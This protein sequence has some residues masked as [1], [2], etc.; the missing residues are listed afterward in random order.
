MHSSWSFSGDTQVF[1]GR[2]KLN[3]F[4]KWNNVLLPGAAASVFPS[5]HHHRI[6]RIS[7][8]ENPGKFG[9]II[10]SSRVWQWWAQEKG[11]S[12]RRRK[13]FPSGEQRLLLPP[14][15]RGKLQRVVLVCLE[16]IRGGMGMVGSTQPPTYTLIHLWMGMGRW[17]RTFL[18]R[19]QDNVGARVE[20]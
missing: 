16:T 7:S 14:Q 2:S 19:G 18:Y 1:Q 13:L 15:A 4:S 5:H 12:Y 17:R 11:E 9:R 10:K 8:S 3:L 6:K 20:S